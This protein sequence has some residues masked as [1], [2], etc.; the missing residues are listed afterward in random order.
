MAGT[1][2]GVRTQPVRAGVGVPRAR[3]DAGAGL[4]GALA[5]VPVA[6]EGGVRLPLAHAKSTL[7]WAR[8]CTI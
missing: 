4:V 8:T 6:E 2:V 1:Q 7:G 5:L 3:A